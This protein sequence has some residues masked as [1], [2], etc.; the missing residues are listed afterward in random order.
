M[1][2]RWLHHFFLNELITLVFCG[3]LYSTETC[4][5]LPTVWHQGC[6][7]V[8]GLIGFSVSCMVAMILVTCIRRLF[9]PAYRL[10]TDVSRPRYDIHHTP[11]TAALTPAPTFKSMDVK[12]NRDGVKLRVHVAKGRPDALTML[13]AAPLGQCGPG[14]YD[15]IRARFGVC[16]NYITW[17]YR[18]SPPTS[19]HTHCVSIGVRL[20]W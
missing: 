19:P 14:I 9:R 16:F 17:D 1:R 5:S 7:M 6:F 10:L 12:T 13:L 8:A 20:G 15:P 11:K 4:S 3:W 2:Q 18:V